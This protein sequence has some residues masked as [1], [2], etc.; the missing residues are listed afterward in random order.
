MAEGEIDDV[1]CSVIVLE[2][3]RV[4]DTVAS[5]E[6]DRDGVF[7]LEGVSLLTESDDVAEAVLVLTSL[8]DAVAE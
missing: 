7:D 2:S 3:L 8:R 6:A 5:R 1:R 4:E